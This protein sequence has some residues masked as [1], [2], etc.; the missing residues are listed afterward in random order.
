MNYT[1]HSSSPEYTV[2]IGRKIAV[3]LGERAVLALHGDLGSGKTCFIK[4]IAKGLGIGGNITSPTFTLIREY[5][6]KRRLFHIDLYR[7]KEI[8]GNFAIDLEDCFS[9]EAVTAIEWA[10]RAKE[11]LPS[12]AIHI[13]FHHGDNEHERIIEIKNW[14]TSLKFPQRICADIERGL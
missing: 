3:L 8:D 5:V 1:I 12:D 13:F 9:K 11:I 4:G 10:E 6:G 7:L 14:P 2:S